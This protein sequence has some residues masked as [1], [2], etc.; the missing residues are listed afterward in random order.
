MESQAVSEL[1]AFYAQFGGFPL[2][3]GTEASEGK[4]GGVPALEVDVPRAASSDDDDDVVAP[5]TLLYL[6][7]GGYVIGSARTGVPLAAAL[8]ARAGV[9][10]WSLDY[11]LAPEDP[12]PAAVDDAVAAY[13]ALVEEVGAERIVVA[14]DS[15]GAGLALALLVAA[16]ERGLPLPAGLVAFSGWFDL[17]LAGESLTGKEAVDP[18][19]DAADIRDYADTYLAG[20]DGAGHLASPFLADLHGFPPLLLQVGTYE[21]LLD[22]TTRLATRA[23]AADVDVRLEVYAGASHVFQHNHTTEPVA[24]RALD[25]AGAFLVERLAAVPRP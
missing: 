12:F 11:R 16:R 6:H 22:D 14:G 4:L 17:T 20:A 3:A 25:S 2:P 15:A 23:A 18:I 13:A 24:T 19:F 5:G 10:A 8:A 9:R 1:R 7:G 21:V